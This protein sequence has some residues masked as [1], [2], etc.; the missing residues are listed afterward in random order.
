MKKLI[1]YFKKPVNGII[2]N[3]EQWKY[4][5]CEIIKSVFYACLIIALSAGM[6]SMFLY[7]LLTPDY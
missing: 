5:L 2:R 3:S 7:A 4:D 1:K 6:V